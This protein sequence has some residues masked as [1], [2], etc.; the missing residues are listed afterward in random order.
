MSLILTAYL[1]KKDRSISM[2]ALSL[3]LLILM[4]FIFTG[5]GV[6]LMVLPLE[7]WIDYSQY[8]YK[9]KYPVVVLGGGI[10]YDAGPE[11]SELSPITLQRLVKGWKLY[12]ELETPLI[13]TGGTGVGHAGD[14]EAGIAGDWLQEAGVDPGNIFLEKNARTTYENGLYVRQWLEKRD[15]SAVY[16]VTSA[17]HMPRSLA[18][19]KNQGIEAL[20]VAGG[21]L[22]SHSLGWL[23]YLPNRG[24][25]NANL[26]ALHE[27]IGIA[28]YKLR[29]RI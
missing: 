18:V 27:I 12:R 24:A 7:N 1:F 11:G 16:L 14:S 17:V 25:L 23:D 20:P 21:F 5:L 4:V 26:S 6:K 3:L 15:Q 28:W 8:N 22:Y 19:F 2:K 29:G 10:H 9:E 13:F